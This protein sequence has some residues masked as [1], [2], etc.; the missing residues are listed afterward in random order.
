MKKLSDI[1]DLKHFGFFVKFLDSD[2]L[3]DLQDGKLFMNTLG[4]FI[5]QEKRTKIRGQG[6]KY[7][8]AH[9]FTV[10]EIQIIDP[11]T[12]KVIGTAKTGVFQERYEGVRDIPVFCFTRFNSDDFA[13]EEETEDEITIRINLDDGTIDRFL[14]NFGDTAV[15]LPGDF[16]EKFKKSANN[17][18]YEFTI[19]P[20]KYEDYSVINPKRKKAFEDLSIGEI[21]SWKDK[22][23]DYQREVRFAILNNQSKEPFIF[24][25][26]KTIEEETIVGKSEEFLRNFRIKFKYR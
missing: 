15:L 10:G 6:D 9:V 3:N 26:D 21:L 8:G 11:K 17:Q 18:G 25:L 19:Q 7:E 14:Q 4:S 24:N 23:F 5:E 16:P 13:V 20:C 1:E 2:Y 12:N 22:F